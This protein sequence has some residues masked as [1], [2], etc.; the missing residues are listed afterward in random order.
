M[1]R[2][3]MRSNIV[4]A[5]SCFDV[6]NIGIDILL[7]EEVAPRIVIGDKCSRYVYSIED[8]SVW[9]VGTKV[10]NT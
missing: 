3:M 5:V 4:F 6:A 10:C 9:I 2:S 7:E 1:S 8:I